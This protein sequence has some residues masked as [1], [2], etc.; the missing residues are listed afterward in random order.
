MKRG[1]KGFGVI[2]GL[3]IV[4]IVLLVGF[5]GYYVYHSRNSTSATS[6]NP[7][8]SSDSTIYNGWQSYSDSAAEYSVKLPTGWKFAKGQPLLSGGQ[9]ANDYQGKPIIGPD[10]FL[11]TK[12][13]YDNVANVLQVYTDN[14]NLTPV[15]YYTQNG[16]GRA[17]DIV[18]Q[19][20]DPINGYDAYSAKD[21]LGGGTYYVIILTHKGKV[22]EYSYY[23]TTQYADDMNKVVQSTKFLN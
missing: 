4:I 10:E 14:S 17:G 12:V 16:V 13:A 21:T 9:V 18:S 7:T 19:N 2:E 3:L 23:T 20:S 1:Q 5:I 8:N 22:V 6:N 15:D 11:P